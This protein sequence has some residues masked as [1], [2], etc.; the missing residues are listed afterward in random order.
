MESYLL[1]VYLARPTGA[2]NAITKCTPHTIRASVSQLQA[3]RY[4]SSKSEAGPS[5]VYRHADD[6]VA[7]LKDGITV[8]SA[9]FGLCGVPGLSALH[10]CRMLKTDKSIRNPS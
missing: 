1:R 10:I 2:F 7:D 5:K 3:R 8:L 9:G 4:S 6:A